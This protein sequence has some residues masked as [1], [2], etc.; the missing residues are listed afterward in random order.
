MKLAFSV[1]DIMKTADWR[2]ESTLKRFYHV[3]VQ[4][5]LFGHSILSYSM[6]VSGKEAL[7]YTVVYAVLSQHRIETSE[8]PDVKVEFCW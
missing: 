4:D 1:A 6:Y 7:T 3:P 8:G 5:S 2:R